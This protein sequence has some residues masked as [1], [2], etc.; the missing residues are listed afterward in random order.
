MRGTKKIRERGKNGMQGREDLRSWIDLLESKGE[1][2][3][4]KTEV[5]WDREIGAITRLVANKKG[6]ALLFENIKDYKD[7]R[8]TKLFTNGLGSRS[9]VAMAIGLPPDTSFKKLTEVIR[10]RFTKPVSSKL[11]RTGPIKENIVSG[12]DVDLFEFPVPKWHHQDGG[13]YINTSCSVVTRDPESGELNV[14]T[15]RGM[16][17]DRRSIGVLLATTQHW[18]CHF[19]KYSAMKKPMPVAVV[20]GWH[21]TLL[22][23]STCPIQHLGYS[24]YELAGALRQGPMELVRCET[25]DLLV[26]ADAEIVIEGSISP[27]REDFVMEGPF[28]EY[29][30][31]YGGSKS[32][33]P[34]IK[35]DCITHRNNPIFRGSLE[36]T[37]PGKWCESPYYVVPCLSAALWNAL[38]SVGIPGIVDVWSP[39]VTCATHVRVRIRKIYRGQAQQV[40]NAIWGMWSAGWFFKHVVV[41]DEDIDIRDDEAVEWAIA[42]RVN[43]GMDDILFFKRTFG[44]LLDPSVPL[45][46]RDVLK[47][48]QGK[49]TRV[50][51]DATK[52]WELGKQEQYGGELYPPLATEIEP[53]IEKFVKKRWKEYELD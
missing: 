51:V 5:D 39:P 42:Y 22:M 30:G 28:G 19:S 34:C 29:P 21:P 23:T 15:Y 48:G 43:A 3:R 25:S 7:A 38:A 14:G 40:A 31:Y 13:R 52:N 32:P 12:E 18:G 8:C 1:L 9:R 6:P 16:V 33:K 41:V 46:E 4:V 45:G 24:E 20:Y 27:N 2:R 44:S 50:L 17:A 49:W 35:V 11:V 37:S 53:D 10:E 47:Y 36:G 26:P